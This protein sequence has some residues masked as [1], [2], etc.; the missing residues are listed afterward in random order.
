MSTLR[1]NLQALAHRDPELA[2]RIGWPVDSS[3]VTTDATAWP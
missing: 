3:H 2:T 1:Q